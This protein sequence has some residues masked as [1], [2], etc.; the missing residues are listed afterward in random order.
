MGKEALREENTK[1]ARRDGSSE[2]SKDVVVERRGRWEAQ[3]KGR[4]VK[5]R[6]V[7]ECHGSTSKYSGKRG[8][9][10]E[11]VMVMFMEV[12]RTDLCSFHGELSFSNSHLCCCC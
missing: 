2:A 4:E 1:E 3:D 12:K 9:E 8:D 6:D 7:Q 10:I 11:I 5:E